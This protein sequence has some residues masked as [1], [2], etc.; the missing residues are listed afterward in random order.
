[1]FSK[2]NAFLAHILHLQLPTDAFNKPLLDV[3][4]LPSFLSLNGHT[5]TV[6]QGN[7]VSEVLGFKPGRATAELLEKVVEWQLEFPLRSKEECRVWFA[8]Q[9]ANGHF[10][11]QPDPPKKSKQK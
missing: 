5:N 4:H 10:T 7:E 3:R 6:R 1:M 9:W 11:I 2:Y 8:E